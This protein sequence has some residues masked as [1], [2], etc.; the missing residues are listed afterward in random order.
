MIMFFPAA[1][2][3]RAINFTY[4]VISV[5]EPEIGIPGVGLSM[6]LLKMS[7]YALVY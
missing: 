5:V 3:S 7:G 6:N 1:K 2:M 4:V